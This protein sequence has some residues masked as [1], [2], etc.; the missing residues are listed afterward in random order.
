MHVGLVQ[1]S[2][3]FGKPQQNIADALAPIV[4]GRAD[5]WVLPE[6]FATGYQFR[7]RPELLEL[8][9]HVPDG[10]TTQVLIEKACESSCHIVAGLAERDGDRLYNSAVLVGPSGLLTCY[11][12][13]HLFY[14][15]TLLFSPGDRSFP[16]V[17]IGAA[18]VGVMICFDHLFP[19]SARSLALQGA[20]LI[21]H[22]ANLVLPDLAQRTM[23]VRAL[24]NGLFTATANRVGTEARTDETLT[25]TGQSQIVGPD[26]V[27]LHRMS[28]NEVGYS[29]IEIEIE[30]ARSKRITDHNDKLS[31]RR[32]DQYRL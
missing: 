31:D 23:A 7:D 9:E 10:P 29:V 1:T 20:D 32:P 19:E 16:V 14:R 25:Y 5:V 15:E 21:A 27:M 18:K 3:V 24:E 4:P 8:S 26:G 22:P 2:P 11:R 6:L 28:P 12:K 17:D 13:V 30:R